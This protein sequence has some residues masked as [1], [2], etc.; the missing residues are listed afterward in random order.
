MCGDVI[1]YSGKDDIVE[2]NFDTGKQGEYIEITSSV[3]Y[4]SN[5]QLIPYDFRNANHIIKLCIEG[6]R[7]KLSVLPVV[8][9]DFFAS[10]TYAHTGI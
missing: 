2:H 6:S 8:K 3:F 5:N 9:R 7:D 1:N 4:S 10:Y